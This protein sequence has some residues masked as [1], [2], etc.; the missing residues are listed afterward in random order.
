MLAK[1]DIGMERGGGERA[2]DTRE[3]AIE[4]NFRIPSAL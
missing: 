1:G 4:G 2:E 3:P